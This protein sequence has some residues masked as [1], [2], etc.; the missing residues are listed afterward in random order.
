MRRIYEYRECRGCR[1][2][3]ADVDP[4]KVD[5]YAFFCD[6]DECIAEAALK[7]IQRWAEEG[8]ECAQ[9]VLPKYES[10]TKAE[11]VA[12]E[13]DDDVLFADCMSMTEEEAEKSMRE[14]SHLLEKK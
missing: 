7:R 3:R 2:F 14:F 11:L 4:D 8:L 12:Y 1:R 5:A 10:M 9:K 13:E 6:S